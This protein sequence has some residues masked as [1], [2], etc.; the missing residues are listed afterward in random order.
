LAS[1]QRSRNA[2]VFLQPADAG[3]ALRAG[4][5]DAWSIWDPFY[6][7]GQR[8]PDVHV[9]IDARGVAPSN[10]FFL[11]TRD[12]ATRYPAT[13]EALID[14]TSKAWHWADRHQSEIAKIL[15]DATGVDLETERVV[16]ARSNYEVLRITP[17]VVAQQQSIA[18][19]FY[20][21]KLVPQDVNVAADIWKPAASTANLSGTWR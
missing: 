21:L 8:Y 12:Y 5:V 15:S 11:A 13:V 1:A 9:L 7:V 3:A 17:Q 16:A 10:A 4:N 14:E 18:D 2:P 19:T 20:R 6:A